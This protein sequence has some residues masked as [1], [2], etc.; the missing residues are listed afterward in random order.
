MLSPVSPPGESQNPNVV[1]GAPAQAC[2]II[3]A[4]DT[5]EEAEPKA[6]QLGRGRTGGKVKVLV[7]GLGPILSDPMGCSP[8]GS[9]VHGI[10]QERMVEW[11]AISFSRGSS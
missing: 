1:W 2:S 3:M 9:S 7:T 8:A 10:L 6:T 4:V 5:A 11:V